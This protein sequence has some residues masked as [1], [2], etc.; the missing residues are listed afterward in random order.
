[1]S[2]QDFT[3]NVII[4]G[5]SELDPTIAQAKRS[6]TDLLG[7]QGDIASKNADWWSAEKRRLDDEGKAKATLFKQQ[8]DGQHNVQDQTVRTGGMFEALG[9]KITAAF[10]ATAI[11]EF[12]RR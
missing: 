10:S 1:M 9:S 11:E 5:R 4:T 2:D 6:L 3:A 7:V 12:M 8:V